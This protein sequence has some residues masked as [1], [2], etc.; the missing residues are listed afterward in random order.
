MTTSKRALHVLGAVA[1]TSLLVGNAAPRDAHA[2]VSNATATV[3]I[4]VS[5]PILQLAELANGIARGV[6]VAVAQ[7]NATNLVPGV[8]FKAEVL[9]DTINNSNNPE[10]DAANARTFIA[11]NTVIGEVGPL[12]SGATK[13]SEAVYNL[14]G[15]VQISPSN[16]NVDLTNPKLRSQYEPRAASGHGPITY[17]RTVT[18]DAK[19]G[20]DDAAY[21]VK[22]LK[23]KRIAVT[24]NTDPYGVGLAASFK[25]EAI[26]LGATIVGGGELDPTLP[27]LGADQLATNISNASGGKVDLVFFGGEYDSHTG[28]GTFLADALKAVGLD[29]YFMGGDGLYAQDFITASSNGGV[30]KSYASSIGP[31]ALNFPAAKTFLALE[32]KQFPGIPTAAYD[33]ESYDAANVILQAYAKAVKAGRIKVGQAQNSTSRSIVALNVGQTKNWPGGSG[34]ITFDSNGDLTT[35]IVSMYK[36]AGSGKTAHWVYAGFAPQ[37]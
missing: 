33:V 16:T 28:G 11:D 1:L 37:P 36:V 32:N 5:V 15:L 26:K 29:T 21:A 10:K 20:P 4:G 9:D 25:A 27:K 7:A 13:G 2:S 35:F 23:A 12:N 31:D 34:S 8:T 24:D 22:V 19:Q 6:K 14:N 3:T 17:F 30:L 18:T